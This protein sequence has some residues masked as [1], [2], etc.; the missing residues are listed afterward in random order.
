VIVEAKPDL[1]S[2]MYTLNAHDAK[3]RRLFSI[4]NSNAKTTIISLPLCR[5]ACMLL[6]LW[7]RCRATSSKSGKLLSYY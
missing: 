1:D 4:G 2:L 6:P 5:D 7:A 3:R